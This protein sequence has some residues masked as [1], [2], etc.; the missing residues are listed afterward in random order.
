MQSDAVDREYA[1]GVATLSDVLD[2]RRRE[3]DAIIADIDT[4]FQLAVEQLNLIKLCGRG[5]ISSGVE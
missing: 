3:Y 5:L 4:R 2:A 1:A